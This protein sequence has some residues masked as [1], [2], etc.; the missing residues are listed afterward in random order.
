MK[1]QFFLLIA[2]L[3][4]MMASAYEAFIDGIYYYFN[5]AAKTATVT[6]YSWYGITDVFYKGEVNIP[7]TVDYNGETYTVTEIGKS[8][9]SECS[10]LTSVTIPSSVTTIGERAFCACGLPSITIP[11]SVTTIGNVAFAGCRFTSFTIPSSVTTIGESAFSNCNGLTSITIPSSV[12]SLGREAFCGCKNLTSVTLPESVTSIEYQ[13][14]GGCVNLP[15]ITIPTSVTSIGSYAFNQCSS[16]TSITIPA[17]VTTIGNNAFSY[18]TG[19][20][21]ITI[22]A[23]VTSI[24]RSAFYG[25]GLSSIEVESGNT[26]YDSRD[27]CNAIIVTATNELFF[28]CKNSFIPDGVESIGGT[29]FAYE[30]DSFS[31]CTGLT[32]I[33]IPASVTRIGSYAFWNCSDLTSV[34]I[35]G[36]A[37]TI[38]QEAFNGCTALRT[39]RSYIKEPNNISKF[40]EGTYRQGTLYVPFG[41]K[42]LYVRFDGWREFL[43]IEEMEEGAS[44]N[45]KGACATPT[46]VVADNKFRFQCKTP[47]AKF[48]SSLTTEEQT[49]EG[50]EVRMGDEVT[51]ILTVYANAPGYDRSEPAIY[52]FTIN[53]SDVNGDGTVDVADISTIISVMAEM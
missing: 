23:S 15:S 8:A 9:F 24:G 43:H 35:G 20:T 13:T 10:E 12:T 26:V 3:M 18:C 7:P 33:N 49:F 51:Y 44:P 25:C 17:S 42:D 48:T 1:K 22:P 37:V 39:V 53:K 46:I 41:T 32:S 45:T 40:D 30:G 38:E 52:K 6:Y 2:L 36:S 47:G 27:N 29:A 4:P 19:L 34:T 31:G 16:L 14:F 21:S 5:H 28:G 11:E 50:D